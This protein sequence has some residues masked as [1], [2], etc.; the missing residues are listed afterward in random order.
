[1]TKN[2]DNASDI[3]I[4]EDLEITKTTRRH[5]V[6]GSWVS[7]TL[8]AHRFEA[9]VFPEHAENP[10]YEIDDSRISKLW[11]QRIADRTVTFNWDRGADIQASDEM[12]KRIVDFLCAGLAESTYG[13]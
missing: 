9:L 4:G 10:D 1:M 13:H 12:T 6:G 11:I 8:N 7:G 3:E 5:S 2:N